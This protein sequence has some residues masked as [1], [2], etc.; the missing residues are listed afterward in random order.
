VRHPPTLDTPNSTLFD[1]VEN[2]P[3]P[4]PL[5][6]K[7]H[8]CEETLPAPLELARA[9]HAEATVPAAPP[10]LKE[11][12]IIILHRGAAFRSLFIQL[13]FQRSHAL[14]NLSID[15]SMR[16]FCAAVEAVPSVT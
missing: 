1:Q 3:N 6:V 12:T 4:V 10:N 16:H 13:V 11:G 5:P 7:T 14:E 15:Q 8:A 9:V 2:G